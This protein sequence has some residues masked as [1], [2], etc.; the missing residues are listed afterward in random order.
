MDAVERVAR[1]IY[2][3]RPGTKKVSAWSDKQREHCCTQARV[4]IAEY[5]A[6]LIEQGVPV[7]KLLSGEM[8]AAAI[9]G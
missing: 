6:W 7:D 3:W 4:A 2:A 9:G 8:R 1:A 5:K